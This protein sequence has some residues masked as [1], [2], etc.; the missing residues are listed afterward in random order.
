MIVLLLSERIGRKRRR[1]V[2]CRRTGQEVNRRTGSRDRRAASRTGQVR[3]FRKAAL[4]AQGPGR[5]P[6]A[7]PG[8]DGGGGRR[9]QQEDGADAGPADG[10]PGV[11]GGGRTEA[12]RRGAEVDQ[13]TRSARERTAVAVGGRTKI[14]GWSGRPC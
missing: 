1:A 10:G 12:M 9:G 7:A 2:V 6:A 5:G 8:G 4:F 14:E 11:P 3:T 13:E